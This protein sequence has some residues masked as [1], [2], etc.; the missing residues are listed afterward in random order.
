MYQ[1]LILLLFLNISALTWNLVLAPNTKEPRPA[2]VD[3]GVPELVL[4]NDVDDVVYSSVSTDIQSSCYSI[5]P[6]NSERAAQLMANKIRDYGLA[7]Q[8]RSMQSMDTLNFFV[9]IP[10]LPSF[11]AAEKT[12]ED[13]AKFDVSGVSILTEGPYQNAISLGFFN[14]LNKA[15]RH[16][17]YIRYLGHDAH[18]TEQ[19]EPREV[20][21]VDYDEPFGS[22]TPVLA[23]SSVIDPTSDV[24]RIPRSCGQTLYLTPFPLMEGRG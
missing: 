9:Y 20:Y 15:R 3:A 10:P 17:E 12:A 7:V 1:L 21:W 6:Y 24:Q 2:L 19:K 5:G 23:W 4:R 11:E 22:N 8:I 14:N 13:I 18:Y 16:A